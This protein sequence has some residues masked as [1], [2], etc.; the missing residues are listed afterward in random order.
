MKTILGM[1]NGIKKSGAR[2]HLEVHIGNPLGPFVGTPWKLGENTLP[3]ENK[4]SKSLQPH[5]LPSKE[6][7][8]EQFI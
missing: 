6:T 5:P 2:E 4:N 7:N 3:I 8:M 1:A